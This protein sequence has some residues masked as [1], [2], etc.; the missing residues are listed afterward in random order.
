MARGCFGALRLAAAC[1]T[2]DKDS[3]YKQP[4]KKIHFPMLIF[5]FVSSNFFSNFPEILHNIRFCHFLDFRV[6]SVSTMKVLRGECHES[7]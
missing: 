6:L 2:H 5:F 7:L 1:P 4:K 3:C